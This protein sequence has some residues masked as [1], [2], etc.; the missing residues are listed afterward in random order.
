MG[1]SAP[2]GH[3]IQLGNLFD[4]AYPYPQHSDYSVKVN[5]SPPKDYSETQLSQIIETLQ[6]RL[7]QQCRF[8]IQYRN[9]QG[10][11]KIWDLDRSEFRFHNRVLYLF[12]YVPEAQSYY[13][14][15]HRHF[16]NNNITFRID[17]ILSVNPS[18]QIR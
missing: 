15:Q 2:A 18:S 6:E 13:R 8:T 5:F 7:T 17:R 11:E 9:A 4:E 14:H 10:D 3:I 1:F 16:V 12:S